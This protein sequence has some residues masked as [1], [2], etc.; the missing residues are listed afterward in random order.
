MTSA[1]IYIRKM[2]FQEAKEKF[3]QDIEKL[4]CQGIEEV[5]VI[6]GVGEYVLRNMVEKEIESID[7]VELLQQ[8]I[9]NPGALRLKIL[10]PPKETM[11]RYFES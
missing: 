10:V 5:E 2:R 8:A 3:L 7:Y 9:P 11:A 1:S 6:H 4:F